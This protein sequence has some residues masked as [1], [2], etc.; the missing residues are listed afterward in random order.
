M[1][2]R[3]LIGAGKTRRTP[4]KARCHVVVAA[5][6]LGLAF[7]A[8]RLLPTSVAHVPALGE[9]SSGPGSPH[10]GGKATSHVVAICSVLALSCFV[11]L[12]STFWAQQGHEALEKPELMRWRGRKTEECLPKKSSSIPTDIG[13]A[14]ARADFWHKRGEMSRVARAALRREQYACFDFMPLYMNRPWTRHPQEGDWNQEVSSNAEWMESRPFAKGFRALV[15]SFWSF[16]WRSNKADSR[17]SAL[18][19]VANGFLPLIIVHIGGKVLKAAKAGGSTAEIGFLCGI[20][21]A[22]NILQSRT[23]FAFELT[24]PLAGLR[25]DLAIRLQRVFMGMPPDTAA[26]WRTGRCTAFINYDVDKAIDLV[27]MKLFA[28][29]ECMTAV[30]ATLAL[31]AYEHFNDGMAL[32][33]SSVICMILAGLCWLNLAS[34]RSNCMRLAQKKRNWFM[35]RTATCCTQLRESRE[36]APDEL[37][38]SDSLLDASYEFE[39]VAK[40]FWRRTAHYFFNRLMAMTAPVEAGH[41]AQASI[42]FVTGCSVLNGDMEISSAAVLS[43]SVSNYAQQLEKFVSIYLDIQEGLVSLHAIAHVFNIDAACSQ[44]TLDEAEGSPA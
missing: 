5:G 25:C 37:A 22:V 44:E 29:V 42:L 41:L 20:L 34:R 40:V 7:T 9:G 30:S 23:K 6:M 16:L 31:I 2:V 10:P 33:T 26:L 3:L 39:D 27:W 19:A 15:W 13:H 12:L 1:D 18:Y 36:R 21:M 43:I 38:R 8:C 28:I 24:V 32:T 17:M 11:H 14:M 4:G 35:A